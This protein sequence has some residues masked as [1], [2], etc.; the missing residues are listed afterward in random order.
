MCVES[1]SRAMVSLAL[2][3]KHG[4]T[5]EALQAALAGDPMGLDPALGMVNESDPDEIKNKK[6]KT[7]ALLRRIR[8]RV[9]EGMN[10]NF[11]DFK[12]Y[13]SLDVAWDTPF[14]QVSATLVQ[15]LMDNNP[16]EEKVYK[17]FQDWGLTHLISEKVDP[18]DST[19]KI[20]EL[21][22]PLFFNIF[23]PLVQAYV[24]IR[25]SKIMNDRRLTPFFEYV[26]AKLTADN[27]A[28]CSAITDR[29]QIISNQYGYY[30]VQKQAV[31]KM[32]HYG[33]CFQFV[34]EAWHVE[35]QLRIA[36][37]EDVQLQNG[38]IITPAA[39][40]EPAT[41]E[42]KEANTEPAVQPA[43]PTA[44]P[45]KPLIKEGDEIVVT[46]REGLRYHMPHPTRA[47]YDIAHGAYT[48]N[49]DSGCEFCGYW[50]IERWRTLQASTFWNKDRIALGTVDLVSANPLFF[51]SVYGAQ[52]MNTPC[53]V[54]PPPVADGAA[55]AFG[56]GAGAGS[57]D[58]EKQL[59]QLYYGTEHGDQGVIVTEYFE[60]L[61]P[62]DWGIGDYNYPVW[63]RFCVAGDGCTV[64]Y[65]EPLP[66]V[67]VVYYGYDED[68]SK[69]K[70]ASMSL[71]ILPFQD[72]F[73]NVLTQ[74]VLTAKQ[75]L[76]NMVFVDT[77]QVED[78]FIEKVKNVGEKMFRTLN[79]FAFSSKKAAKYQNKV[80][81]AMQAFKFPQGNTSELTTVLKTI[82]DVLERVLVMSSNEVGQAASHE[83]TKEEIRNIAENTSSRLVFTTT[84]VDIA[85]EAQKRQ[86]YA[87]LMNYG[88]KNFYV[89]IPSDSVL[90]QDV[91]KS[92]GFTF[93][94]KQPK[95]KSNSQKLYE[96]YHVGL[97][98][99]AVDL[100]QFA[101]ARDQQDRVNNDKIAVAL[102][103]LFQEIMGNPITAQAVGANQAI[104]WANQ[105]CYF[106]GMPRDFK[107]HSIAPDQTP[108]QQQAAAQEQLKGVI[109][110]VLSQVDEKLK[111]DLTPLLEATGQ[112]SSDIALLFKALNVAAP[113]PADDNPVQSKTPVGP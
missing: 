59:A 87:G 77:D 82:L 19:K 18:K 98:S 42:T 84:P 64:L 55:G 78:G 1:I 46:T 12:L 90:T 110:T 113:H 22:I 70:N 34:K 49:Y 83:Q 37:I 65:A 3:R 20:R 23:V 45:K 108:E 29:V 8:S 67:P 76:A 101:S 104:D 54:I 11:A 81:D 50:R 27:M 71:E 68:A 24:K 38:G 53:Q 66:F 35:E 85:A 58:R 96:R 48:L 97:N 94:D 47:F 69:T 109:D 107:L 100:W 60:K 95:P 74:I 111:Q 56:V 43:E 2:L 4:V 10:R 93:V 16:S 28:K 14:R 57:L 32:L 40:A 52:V 63:F 105:I 92:M 5:Q 39:S 106:S 102:A 17:A 73:S 89:H 13:H 33:L 41:P 80:A 51:Q 21:N 86:L 15:Q 72:H 30:D 99:V 62:S 88:D 7:A 61:K 79:I 9:Q 44:E 112:N 36:T 75:N 91:L 6:A 103:Q 25:W 31:L 26:P